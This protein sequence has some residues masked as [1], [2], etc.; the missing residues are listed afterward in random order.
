MLKSAQQKASGGAV[1]NPPAPPPDT[2]REIPPE[3]LSSLLRGHTK[4][5]KKKETAATGTESRTHVVQ[6]GETLYGIAEKYYGDSTHWKRIRDANRTSID[7][8]WRV[9]AGQILVIP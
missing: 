2:S 4:T 8:N 7:P 6:P 5:D 3:T 9:R 1:T